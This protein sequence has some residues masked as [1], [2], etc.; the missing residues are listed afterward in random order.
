MNDATRRA[1]RTLAQF[2]VAGGFTQVIDAY[3]TDL[4]GVNK[5]LV[6]AG[7]QLVVTFSQNYLEDH[8]AFPA[9]LKSHASSGENPVTIDPAA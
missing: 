5:L 3:V 1:L 4:D 2:I 9:V 7:V 8:T 6:L